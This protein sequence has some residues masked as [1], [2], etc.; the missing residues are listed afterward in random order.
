MMKKF[1]SIAVLFALLCGLLPATAWASYPVPDYGP[2]DALEKFERGTPMS[3]AHRAAWRMGPENSL[4]AIEAGIDMGIDVVELD[5]KLTSDKEVVLSHD[6]TI[7]RCVMGSGTVSSFTWEQL[8]EMPVKPGQGG[9]SAYT[10]SQSDAE[11]LNA[12]PSYAQHSGQAVEGGTIPLARLDDA[13]DL[14]D[15]RCMINLD[16]CF[17]QDL[18]VACYQ[19]FREKDFLDYVFFK[20]SVSAD[21]MNQW[22]AAAAESWNSAH[23]EDTIT[24]EKVQQSI[25]YVYIIGDASYDAPQ[26]H[27]ENGD[28]LVMVEIVIQDD[29]EDRQVQNVVE[30][31][32]KENGVAMFVNTMWSGLCSTKPDTETT[33]AEMLDRGYAAIQT[34]RPS[35]LSCYLHE[36]NSARRAE[37]VV[38]AE[39][40]HNFPYDS[41]GFSV[42]VA[43]DDS[44]NK[45]VQGMHSGDWMSYENIQ[46]DG[47][48]DLINLKA[49]GLAEDVSVH[50]YVDALDADHL[51]ATAEMDKTGGVYQTITA[52]MTREVPAGAHTLYVEASGMPGNSL[53]SLDCFQFVSLEDMTGDAVIQPVQVVT[54]PGVLPQLPATVDVRFDS[55]VFGLPVDWENISTDSYQAEGEFTV[56]GYV[57]ALERYIE[58]TVTVRTLVGEIPQEGLALWLDAAKGVTTDESG[59]VTQWASQAG[60]ITATLKTGNPSLRPVGQGKGIY[61]DGSTAFDLSMDGENTFWNNKEE[62]TVLLYTSAELDTRGAESGTYSQYNSVLYFGETADWGSAYFTPSQ[63]EVIFR[64]GSGTSQ[65]YGTTYERDQNIGSIFT[66]TAIRKDGLNNSIFVDEELIYDGRAASSETKNISSSGWI[67]LGKNNNYFKGTVCEVLIYDRALSDQEIAAAQRSLAEKYAQEITEVEPVSVTCTEGVA[68]V[69]PDM[70]HVTFDSG[71]EMDLQVAWDTPDPR[72]YLQA[73]SFQVTGKLG[74]GYQVTAQVTVTASDS[75]SFEDLQDQLLLRFSAQSGITKDEDNKVSQWD[76]TVSGQTAVSAAQSNSA[77]QPTAIVDGEGQITGVHFD[78]NDILPFSLERDTFNGKKELTAVIYSKPEQAAPS[79]I[80]N[81]HNNSVLY[82]EEYGAGWSG[83]YVG[84]FTNGATGRFGT[85]SANYRG[86]LYDDG[87]YSGY[88]TT[89]LQKKGAQTDLLYLNGELISQGIQTDSGSAGETTQYINGAAGQLG[90]GKK[91]TYWSGTV[92]EIMVFDGALTAEELSVV[93]D[94][95]ESTYEQAEVPE[96]GL[97]FW[98]DAS[99]GVTADSEGNVQSW[100]SKT[101]SLTAQVKTSGSGITSFPAYQAEGINGKGTI[102]FDGGS[103]LSLELAE[104]ALNGLTGAT[105]IAYA[106]P[107]IPLGS[108]DGHDAAWWAQRNTLFSVDESGSWGSVYLGVYTDA[109]SGRL[110]TGTDNDAGVCSRRTEPITGYTTTVLRWDGNSK[111]YQVEADG[112]PL[113]GGA[114]KASQTGNNKNIVYLGAGKGGTMWTGSVSEILFYNRVLSDEEVAGVYRYLEDKYVP[115]GPLPVAVTGVYLKEANTQLNLYVGDESQLT[116]CT[117]PA[118]ADETGLSWQSSNPGVV[119][120]DQNGTVTA[121]QVGSAVITVTTT[122]GGYSKSCSVRVNSTAG[123]DLFADIQ[124]MIRWAETQNGDSLEHWDEMEAAIEAARALTESS[125]QQDLQTAYD[126]LRQAKMNLTLKQL[127]VSFDTRCSIEVEPATVPYGQTITQVDIHR[128]GYTLEGW[129]LNDV[130]FDFTTPITQDITL[131]AKWTSTSTSGGG[132]STSYAITLP[133]KMENGSL[134]VTPTRA[135]KG[136]TVTIT[137]RPDE[138]YELDK[139]IATDKNG[140]SIKLTSKGN[141]QYSFVMP[142]SK[143]TI[144]VSFVKIKESSVLDRF[145]DITSD[146]WYASAV[147]FVVEKGLMAGTSGNT[148]EP[149]AVMNRA[150]IWTV[151][152]AYNGANT[153]G[154]NPWYAPSQQWAVLNG[155]SDGTSPNAPITREQLAVMLWRAAGSPSTSKSLSNYA[156]ADNISNWAMEALAWAV[157]NGIIFGTGDNSLAPKASATRAQ[158]SVMLMHFVNCMEG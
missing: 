37:D 117:I 20:N 134:S 106:D 152:A 98:M 116:A 17:S 19:E 101:G 119:S 63:N 43:C 128:P 145:T 89:V 46:F 156:D 75:S 60:E 53:V 87:A 147:E 72:S 44:L 77:A 21:T 146:A 90:C 92:R 42:P 58:A 3:V 86:I 144:E 126:A 50:F 118:N 136:R 57:D 70:V 8:K 69:L 71:L 84:T 131:T 35:E 104:N 74:N 97:L 73:G 100:A 55:G 47:S 24:A 68:P 66:G 96:D 67:G 127:T 76:G 16:H 121:H 111:T 151:L 154:G 9:S 29:S 158:A 139:L 62:F 26:S 54:E 157:D 82:F 12:L 103:A 48:E 95:L 79:G 65:D 113:A 102:Q 122:E 155:I 23:P 33:W 81:N 7:D 4:I 13:I 114:S 105:I 64:F 10:L 31:W 130:L 2:G 108:G 6:K 1:L 36:I 94:Y 41:Y 22:Y 138:G 123:Q 91:N 56:L 124:N 38:Q 61:F 59:N 5:V 18:F 142:G 112:T 125:S 115:A 137:V 143:V 14:I 140:S 129:Y 83:M 85:G 141:N 27:L 45:T 52:S 148:F 120:V 99:S 78:G 25:K 109:V 11:L 110:G 88:T 93:S 135:T 153:S 49:A 107:Q 39:H 80:K 15:K 30:P 34:D 32:C 149:D 40:F 150:M 28:N 132:G 133:S 51:I